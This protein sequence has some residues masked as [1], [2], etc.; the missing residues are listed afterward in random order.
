LFE[1]EIAESKFVITV[2]RN[3]RFE[4]PEKGFSIVAMLLNIERR[5]DQL[6]RTAERSEL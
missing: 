1:W 3:S 5:I 4:G 2:G 6:G